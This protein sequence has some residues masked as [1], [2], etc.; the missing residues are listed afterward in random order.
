MNTHMTINFDLLL[1]QEIY[2]P[3]KSR[4]DIIKNRKKSDIDINIEDDENSR[5]IRVNAQ[6]QTYQSI[7]LFGAGICHTV[8]NWNNVISERINTRHGS[9]FFGKKNFNGDAEELN[10]LEQQD[11]KLLIYL[12]NS[13]FEHFSLNTKRNN[14]DLEKEYELNREIDFETDLG[15]P[16]TYIGVPEKYNKA[17]GTN[18]KFTKVTLIDQIYFSNVNVSKA[19]I[20]DIFCLGFNVSLEDEK[21][22]DYLKNR[23]K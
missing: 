23:A 16:D 11:K 6:A 20:V 5:F 19:S 2:Y 4:V 14:E 17:F 22:N 21:R 9:N 18:F 1:D 8:Y 15:Y 3:V 10:L 12:P 13:Y 7:Y